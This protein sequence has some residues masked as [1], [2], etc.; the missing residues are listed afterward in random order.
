M[1]SPEVLIQKPPIE[2]TFL[3]LPLTTWLL[4]GGIGALVIGVAL[5]SSS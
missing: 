5:M 2:P 1:K 4:I 3:N